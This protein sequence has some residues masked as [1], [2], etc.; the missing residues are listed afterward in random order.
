MD[1][2][3]L[4]IKFSSTASTDEGVWTCNESASTPSTEPDKIDNKSL[5]STVNVSPTN[6][7]NVDL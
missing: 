1:S 5:A 6:R 2:P 7:T 3:S 4:P